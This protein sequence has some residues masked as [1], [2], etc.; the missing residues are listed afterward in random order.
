MHEAIKYAIQHQSN[1]TIAWLDLANAYGSVRHMLMAFALAWYHVPFAF[2]NIIFN[3]YE[4]LSGQIDTSSWS[5]N[6]FWIAKGLFQGCTLSTDLFNISFQPILDIHT[7]LANKYASNMMKANVRLLHPTFAD[8]VALVTSSPTNCTAS[9]R[10][11]QKGLKWSRCF[12]L[13]HI[14]CRSLAFRRFNKRNNTKFIPRQ[15]RR[16]SSYDPLL[17]INGHAIQ[18]IGDDDPPLFK[19]VGVKIQ[20]TFGNI[21]SQ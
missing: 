6:I 16:F 12:V 14:K 1:I 9:Q 3:Y 10:V 5:S 7:E 11:F 17:K 8:D 21:H 20:Y 15:N 13:K 18:Y 4:G 19:Y 2:R